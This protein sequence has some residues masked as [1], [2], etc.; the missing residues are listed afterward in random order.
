MITE[1]IILVAILI[2]VISTSLII[3]FSI[4]KMVL[5]K[6]SS[7]E[8]LNNSIPINILKSVM[9]ISLS[10]L[11]S[12]LNVSLQNISKVILRSESNGSA[13]FQG[14]SYYSIFIMIFMF[15]FILLFIISYILFSV[16]F[17]GKDIFF[18]TANNN[19][20]LLIFFIGLY[21]MLVLTFKP[22]LLPILDYFIAYPSVI[23]H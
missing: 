15:F 22:N 4:N 12:E 17:R 20:G 19:Y 21:L 6:L 10:L 23:Y 8:D 5:K 16:I 11:M 14:L 1:I 9:L 18:E 3:N 7:K 13:F 2:A